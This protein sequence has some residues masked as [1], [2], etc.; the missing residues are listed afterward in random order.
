MKRELIVMD[1]RAWAE[2][3]IRT[4]NLGNNIGVSLSIVARYYY[5]EEK[6]EKGELV[7]ALRELLLRYN[8]NINIY[9]YTNLINDI[10][11]GV[12][13][14]PLTYVP[15]LNITKK[16]VD[17]VMS[18]EGKMARRVLFA[19]L[20]IAKFGNA[21]TAKNNNWVNLPMSSVFAYSNV[22]TSRSRQ[23]III[24]S[25][26]DAGYIEYSP[27]IDNLNIR[28]PFID[29]SDSF[30]WRVYDFDNLGYQLEMN[31]GVKGYMICDYCGRITRRSNNRQKYCRDCAT[32][33][34]IIKTVDNRKKLQTV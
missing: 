10:V 3:A 18:V 15:Y 25:L 32:K 8:P 19:L 20:C 17:V 12:A 34:N 9:A 29:D 4:H 7:S 24:K 21:R 31:S 5:Y 28:V 22:S 6:K 26:R 23:D 27:I 11:S 33:V 16:E 13:K 1:E 2:D 30:V 14:Y